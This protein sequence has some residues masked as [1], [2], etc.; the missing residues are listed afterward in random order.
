MIELKKFK[1]LFTLKEV[2]LVFKECSF[3]STML[4]RAF[5]GGQNNK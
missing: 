3:T 4:K 2:K 1:Y 5:S